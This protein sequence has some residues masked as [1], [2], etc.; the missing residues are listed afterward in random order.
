LNGEHGGLIDFL[1][2]DIVITLSALVVVL[3]SV[4]S[5]IRRFSGQYRKVPASL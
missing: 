4:V 1:P 2:F 5:F 3:L